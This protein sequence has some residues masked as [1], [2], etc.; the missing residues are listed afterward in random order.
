MSWMPANLI[1]LQRQLAVVS[2]RLITCAN[3]HGRES[4][5][6]SFRHVYVYLQSQRT[7]RRGASRAA[8]TARIVGEFGI[9]FASCDVFERNGPT[10]PSK[11][12][13]CHCNPS[14]GGV[15]PVQQGGAGRRTG[16]EQ[17]TATADS[18]SGQQQQT[19]D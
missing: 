3:D 14:V 18:N 7:Q 17:R 1:Q 9:H 19:E 16:Q 15:G 12:H 5:Q 4:S 6:Q 13:Q 8:M 2:V 10:A 11:G